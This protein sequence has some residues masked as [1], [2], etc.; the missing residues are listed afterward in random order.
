MTGYDSMVPQAAD[1]GG[2]RATNMPAMF[3]EEV[4]DYA[5]ALIP[6]CSR[7]IGQ[8]NWLVRNSKCVAD[9]MGSRLGLEIWPY[10]GRLREQTLSLVSFGKTARSMAAKAKGLGMKI[11]P[12]DPFLDQ[13]YFNDWL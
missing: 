6:T 2:I 3:S 8:L 1:E 7:R 11:V 4:E 5:M 10:L 12:F 9:R 13:R